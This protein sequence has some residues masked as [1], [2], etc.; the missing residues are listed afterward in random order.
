MQTFVVLA[1]RVGEFDQT[2]GAWIVGVRLRAEDAV[3]LIRDE[4]A[5]DESDGDNVEYSVETHDAT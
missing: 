3:D 2:T 4:K 1:R 5:K